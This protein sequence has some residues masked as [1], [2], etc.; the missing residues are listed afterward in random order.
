[1]WTEIDGGTHGDYRRHGVLSPTLND[2]GGACLG[3]G[4]HMVGL[5]EKI[6]C[7]ELIYFELRHLEI[8]VV[9]AGGLFRI[10]E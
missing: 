8:R 4:M 6:L 9:K 7:C 2:D 5:E 1:M 3:R 10:V